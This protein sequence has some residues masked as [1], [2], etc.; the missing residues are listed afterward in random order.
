MR[1]V[2]E[3]LARESELQLLP[4]DG[5]IELRAPGCNKQHA[6]KAVLSETT[7]DSTV[8]YLG[9]DLTDEDAFVAVKPRGL[10]VLVRNRIRPRT[11]AAVA[12]SAA[13]VPCVRRRSPVKHCR[14]T[15]VSVSEAKLAPSA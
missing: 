3:P 11:R 10:A 12:T 2:W 1:A 5:G 4:F 7:A 6:V 15:S 13:S 8:A 14:T 9:D